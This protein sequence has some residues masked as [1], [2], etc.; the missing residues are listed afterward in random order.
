MG[1]GLGSFGQGVL[2]PRYKSLQGAQAFTKLASDLVLS[3]GPHDPL[4]ANPE[5]LDGQLPLLPT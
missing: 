5:E 4:Y 1:G 2:H 3:R